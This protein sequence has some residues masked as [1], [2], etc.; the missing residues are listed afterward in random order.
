VWHDNSGKGSKASWY[1]KHI[2][3]NDLDKRTRSFFI[4]EQWLAVEKEDGLLERRIKTAGHKE[5]T[6]LTYLFKKET[7]S[8]LSDGHLW[9]SLI[10]RPVQSTFS[11]LDRL[12]CIFVLMVVS[13]LANII[14]YGT[15]KS[16]SPNALKIG[17][18]MLTP[19]QVCFFF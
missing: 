19:M 3:V 13:M 15:D 12:T 14:Y 17:P 11:R 6:Q 4:C 18:F 9:F 1:L 8:K 2:I 16:S 5:K 7:Q 10:A